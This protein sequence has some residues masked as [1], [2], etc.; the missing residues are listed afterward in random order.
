MNNNSIEGE[1][2]FDLFKRSNH[3]NEW[4]DE[5]FEKFDPIPCVSVDVRNCGFKVCP[6]DINAFP[7]G[8]NNLNESSLKVA[9]NTFAKFIGNNQK[10][11][12]IPENYTRNLRYLD[13]LWALKFIMEAAGASKVEI[14]H[15]EIISGGAVLQS[16]LGR[17]VE[18]RKLFV[19]GGCVATDTGFTPDI[20]LVNNDM[21][22]DAL[23]FLNHVEHNVMPSPYLGW[24]VRSKGKC[25]NVYSSLV[26]DFCNE[27]KFDP[28]FL[29]PAT[30]EISDINFTD[31]TKLQ[32]LANEVDNMLYMIREEYR[33]HGVMS[34]PYVFVK[35]S[36]GTYGMGMLNIF[37]SDDIL[38]MSKQNRNKI[39]T[40]KG[41]R[42]VSS[43]VIQEGI[44]TI[45]TFNGSCAE[46]LVYCAFGDVCGYLSRYH[47]QR[48]RFQSLN[49]IGAEF[50]DESLNLS[51]LKKFV[52]T[53]VGRLSCLTVA[54]EEYDYKHQIPET[55]SR[56]P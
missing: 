23:E 45:D 15:P 27:F 10:I 26:A 50:I 28:W 18:L 49:S 35:A 7:A 17:V 24:L 20:I 29:V 22:N 39:S 47:N 52:L 41:R 16:Y 51:E 42:S 6:V 30:K 8:F 48:D 54:I 4:L 55:E 1:I 33:L 31:S 56:V 14:A 34:N 43:V 44:S 3:I 13:S 53:L 37:C 12:I 2:F 25:F 46:S 40:I 5:K 19:R 9:S 11:L 21:T 38:N 32:F 36:N